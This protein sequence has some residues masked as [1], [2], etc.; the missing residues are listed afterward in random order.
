[1]ISVVA[2]AFAAATTFAIGYAAHQRY[3]SMRFALFAAQ[4]ELQHPQAKTQTGNVSVADG[5][6]QQFT[7]RNGKLS[8]T[9]GGSI[10]WQTPGGW[11]ADDFVIA[12]AANTG[13][14]YL[15][16]SVWKQGSFGPYR[17]FW[18]AKN[19]NL[20]HNHLFVFRLLTLNG[21]Q[22]MQPVWQSSDLPVPNCSID[23]QKLGGSNLYSLVVTEG[24]YQKDPASAKTCSNPKPD[25]WQWD[26]FGFSKTND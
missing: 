21:V 26:Q 11:W 17:P 24:V 6:S 5:A 18:I 10:I 4:R 7:L 2:V 12:D 25:V 9:Q 20:I 19:D 16:L 1:M 22:S 23:F 3:G 15:V 13:H 14:D 8:V